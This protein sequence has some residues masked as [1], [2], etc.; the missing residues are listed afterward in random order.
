MM[1]GKNI[2]ERNTWMNTLSARL[3]N[4]IQ[5]PHILLLFIAYE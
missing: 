1:L 3:K 5:I 4:K 2:L